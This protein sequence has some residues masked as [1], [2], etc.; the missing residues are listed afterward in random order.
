MHSKFPKAII[1]FN[2]EE[3]AKK[4]KKLCTASEFEDKLYISKSL[5]EDAIHHDQHIQFDQYK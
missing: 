4:F 3:E 5:D 1:K 2:G